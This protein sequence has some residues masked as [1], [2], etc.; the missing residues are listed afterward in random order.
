MYSSCKTKSRIAAA[1]VAVMM[2]L[3]CFSFAD[4]AYAASKKSPY[5]KGDNIKNAVFYIAVDAD[6]NGKITDE[7]D[8][9]YYYTYDEIK[10]AGEEVAYHFGNHGQGETANVKGAKLSTLLDNIEGVDIKDSWVIQYMEEDAFHATNAIYQDTVQ[11]LT[12]ENGVGNGSKAGVAAETIIGYANKTT[13]D[14][15]DANNVD[16]KDYVSFLDYEREASYVRAYRQTNSANESVLKLLKGVVISND[17]SRTNKT[18]PTGAT[19][20]VLK[21]VDANGTTIADD[22]VVQGLLEGMKW[23]ATPNVDVPWADV[24]S[25]QSGSWNG[26]SRIITIDGNVTEGRPKP[27]TAVSF[28][29]IEKTFFKADVNGKKINLLRSN[30]AGEGYEYPTSNVK[31]GTKYTYFGYNKPMFVRYQGIY[32]NNIIDIDSND[33]VY[34][35]NDDGSKIDITD[36]VDDYFV[37]YY[38]T[39]SKSSSNISNRKRVPLNYD[40][41]VLV[42]TKSADLEYSNGDE[43][44]T[45]LSGKEATIYKN[46]EIV[47]ATQPAAVDSISA[48]LSKY[49]SIK[50]SWNKADGADGY[51]I[52]YRTGSGKWS[53][54]NVKG[55]STVLSGLKSDKTYSVKVKAYNEVNGVNVYSDESAVK[56]ATTLKKV[57]LT[58][59]VSSGKAKIKISNIKGESG[60]QIYGKT[61]K[62]SWKLVK[63]LK[64]DNVSYTTS[65]KLKKGKI[66]YVKARA[67]KTVDGKKVYAP[68]SSVKKINR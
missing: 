43:D 58:A 20:Y 63:T 35:L 53:S 48:K 45:P 51:R 25:T 65:K 37:A 41:A 32:L 21:S 17:I 67:Y 1:F 15:P 62:G 9:V 12:D 4:G 52:Y 57:T 60:Y 64:A 46:A 5:K 59:K 18:L 66:Y 24:D 50:A 27:T 14:A 11:G 42:D 47:V 61:S 34:I 39:Q 26:V 10:N 8:A 7:G 49:N 3:T 54:K 2:I 19:G 6:G 13:F 38:Y 16:D 44:Y 55:T 40:K 22:Y 56:S 23:P 30:L 33:K 29:F 68:W 31:D 28:R 36:T